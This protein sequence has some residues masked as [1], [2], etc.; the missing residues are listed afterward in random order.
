MVKLF[1]YCKTTCTQSWAWHQETFDV[2]RG[3]SSCEGV[4]YKAVTTT[5]SNVSESIKHV[6][7]S[8]LCNSWGSYSN[9][10]EDSRPLGHTDHVYWYIV[11]KVWKIQVPSSSGSS[12]L[13]CLEY[14]RLKMKAPWYFEM[15]AVAYQL[16]WHNICMAIYITQ[17][18]LNLKNIANNDL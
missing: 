1:H 3:I 16:S 13:L 18:M 11:T 5:V 4:T 7:H 10:A 8:N 6:R 12:N 15:E 2:H 14:L 9:V 17:C